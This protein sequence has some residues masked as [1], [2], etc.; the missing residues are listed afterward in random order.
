MKE[1]GTNSFAESLDD[2]AIL[3]AT[4]LNP[5]DYEEECNSDPN[6]SLFLNDIVSEFDLW[7]QKCGVEKIK[8][9]GL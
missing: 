8:T 5:V 4:I 7:A 9:I 3:F 2:I 6:S 1:D